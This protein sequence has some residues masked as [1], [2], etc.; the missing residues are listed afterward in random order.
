MYYIFFDY[1]I[2]AG[3]N[4]AFQMNEQC[5]SNDQCAKNTK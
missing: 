2:K 5:F 3:M 1:D 4:S